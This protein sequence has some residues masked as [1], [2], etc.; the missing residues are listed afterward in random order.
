VSF[1]LADCQ[2]IEF[3]G[4]HCQDSPCASVADVWLRM[5][6]AVSNEESEGSEGSP[7]NVAPLVMVNLG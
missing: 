7:L 3:Q 1:R 2:A 4:R 6:F 5:G